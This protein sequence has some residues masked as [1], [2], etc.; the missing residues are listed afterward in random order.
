VHLPYYN[1]W[2]IH[3]PQ[4]LHV[5]NYPIDCFSYIM[6]MNTIVMLQWLFITLFPNTHLGEAQIHVIQMVTTIVTE[7]NE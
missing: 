5:L 3:E 4:H 7:R 1:Q 6:H 2:V